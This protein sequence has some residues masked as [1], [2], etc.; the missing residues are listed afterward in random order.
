MRQDLPHNFLFLIMSS[1]R[2]NQALDKSLMKAWIV[3]LKNNKSIQN[4]WINGSILFNYYKSKSTNTTKEIKSLSSFNHKLALTVPKKFGSIFSQQIAEKI[5]TKTVYHYQFILLNKAT[6]IKTAKNKYKYI[7]NENEFNLLVAHT[8]TIHNND[9]KNP[10][11]SSS[12]T[13]TETAE[14]M[15]LLPSINNSYANKIYP[16]EPPPPHDIN[17]TQSLSS[18]S[19]STV[20][21]INSPPTP[22]TQ[23][24]PPPIQLPLNITTNPNDNSII[25]A[26]QLNLTRVDRRSNDGP[27]QISRDGEQ[28]IPMHKKKQ[29]N[30]KERALVC[31][32]C[33]SWGYAD[34]KYSNSQKLR[35]AKAACNQVSYDC[36]FR[37]IIGFSQVQKWIRN[38]S[39]YLST[40]QMGILSPNHNGG[41]KNYVLSVEQNNK[42]YLTYLWHHAIA[43]LGPKATFSELTIAMNK[44]SLVQSDPRPTLNLHRIQVF[45]WFH[46]RLGKELSPIEKP[47]DTPTHIEKRINWVRKYY[48]LLTDDNAPVA[49]LD[50][51]W[52]YTTNRRNKLKYLP[53]QPG[54][55][56]GADK[57]YK[58]K[59]RCCCHPVKS[60]F[61]GVVARPRPELNFDGKIHIEHVCTS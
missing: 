26:L 54:E 1:N 35:I 8:T 47:L 53:L 9:N 59:M 29:A 33:L 49:Y 51:K 27:Q 7:M 57:L 16:Q 30:E 17:L 42:G 11:T 44:K 52:F 25:Y 58:S 41:R 18:E 22:P 55:T 2:P 31:L 28:F 56:P 43:T 24:I 14:G 32:T 36:G 12:S 50:E 15:A 3:E 21:L 19:D 60:M 40:G 61:L 5:N 23:R 45:R 6:S 13:R 4:K 48:N 38:L 20:I 37:T 39:T 34:S 10:T 46:D